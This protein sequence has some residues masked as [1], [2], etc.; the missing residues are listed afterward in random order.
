MSRLPGGSSADRSLSSSSMMM[1]LNGGSTISARRRRSARIILL[2]GRWQVLL[3][4]FV[5]ERQGQPF[6]FW[7]TP[8]GGVEND[9]TDVDAARRELREELGLD[10]DLMGPVHSHTSEFEHAG[11]MVS[12]TD[13]FFVGESDVPMP[14]LRSATEAE[15]AAMKALRWWSVTEIEGTGDV[16]FP[17]DLGKIIQ[18]INGKFGIQEHSP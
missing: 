17:S 10:I 2:N 13:I 18:R 8:G 6:T 3:I 15:R 12:N 11:E 16:I 4:K 7:A 5:V 14:E 9:E 1:H